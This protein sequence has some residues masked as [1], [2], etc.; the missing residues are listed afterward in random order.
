M[1]TIKHVAA[2]GTEGL[3]E[4]HSFTR[5]QRSD[6]FIQYMAFAE[7]PLPNDYIGTWCGDEERRT[8]DTFLDQTIYVMNQ[9]GA[10]VATY[11]FRQPDFSRECGETREKLAA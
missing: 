2:D 1:L 9:H 11:R 8:S 10:T 4:C 3:V 6:G 5:E 7:R